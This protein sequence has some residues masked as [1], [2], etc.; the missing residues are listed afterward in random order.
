[1]TAEVIPI[2]PSYE[3]LLDEP[4][5]L[6]SSGNSSESESDAGYGTPAEQFADDEN[7]RVTPP[8]SAPASAAETTA[9]EIVVDPELRD[10]IVKQVEFYF[11]DENL[12]KDSF[13]MKHI[14]RNKQGYVSLKLVASFR[15]V[16]SLTKD[17]RVVLTSLRHS[18]I[19]VLS[20]DETKIRRRVP[21][22]QI[23]YSHVGRT[24]IV[25]QY[26]DAEPN[27]KRIEEQFGKYGEVIV[28]RI[29]HPGKAIPLDVK[30]CRSKHP[31]LGKELCIL[32]E[33]DSERGAKVA[34]EKFISQ[35]SWRDETRV[36][37]LDKKPSQSHAQEIEK[38]PKTS[39]SNRKTGRKLKSEQKQ[40]RS[41]KENSPNKF[42]R[43]NSPPLRNWREESPARQVVGK[44]SSNTP[45]DLHQRRKLTRFSP[46]L[47]RRFLHPEAWRDRD[48]H[49][50]SGCSAR[51]P[52]QSPKNS[53]EPS[54]RA[55][56]RD[57]FLSWRMN[58]KHVHVRDGGV[59]RQPLGPDG[60]SGF[61]RQR[62]PIRISIDSC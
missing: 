42:A 46:E 50:D 11:S 37:L 10:R 25:T 44:Y 43:E 8:P 1:M 18:E 2:Q 41:A 30:P 49:S 4:Q 51:S 9:G 13:L 27:V 32:V 54:K 16:K 29:L 34:C 31:A 48:Y 39:P 23:D 22:P 52:S 21:A 12:L 40:N 56:T 19:M 3:R 59:I 17:W 47:P 62:R 24:V 58:E 7:D 26:P 61:Q 38:S 60:T 15:K 33:F 20:E 5:T 14:N 57:N 45:S 36:E 28:V 53:P 35:Q 55:F 6:L